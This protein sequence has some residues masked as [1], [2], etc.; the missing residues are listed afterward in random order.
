[1][2]IETKG[3]QLYLGRP[4]LLCMHTLMCGVCVYIHM[5]AHIYMCVCAGCVCV[6]TFVSLQV[7]KLSMVVCMGGRM[8]RLRM[9]SFTVA[10]AYFLP[11]CR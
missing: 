1:M 9:Y 10:M 6:D 8:E 4:R 2:Q 5:Y 3:V 7:C 11:G